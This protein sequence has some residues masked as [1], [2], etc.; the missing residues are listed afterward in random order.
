[1]PLPSFPTRRSS[2][3]RDQAERTVHPT[4]LSSRSADSCP[5]APFLGGPILIGANGA[6]CSIVISPARRRS[7][8]AR[9]ATA[10][11]MRE[12]SP[13][14]RSEEHTSELQSPYD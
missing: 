5:V 4:V 3:L 8:S 7:S 10:C 2:D 11:S 14:S 9:N 13:T 1:R 6:D 12:S